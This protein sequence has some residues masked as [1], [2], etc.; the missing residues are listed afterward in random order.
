MPN[1]SKNNYISIAKALGI[2]LMVVGHSG[3]PTAIGKFIYLFH[4]PLFFVCSGYF[5]K[6]ISDRPSLF[7][8]YRKRIKGLY[9]PYLK[10]SLLFLLLHNLFRYLHITESVFYQKEDYIRQ[11]IKLIAMTDYELLIRPF[12]FIKELLFTSLI[13]ATIS[14]FTSRLSIK[15]RSV[16]LFVI[17]LIISVISK[18]LSPIPLIGDCSVLCLSIL[19]YYTGILFHKYRHYIPITYTTLIFSFAFVFTG[20]IIF[21]GTIDMRF[22]NIYNQIPYYLLSIA[23]IIMILCISQ[24]HE[25]IKHISA[26]YYIGNHTMPILALNLLALKLGSLLKIWIYGLPIEQLSSFTVIYEY[27]SWYW[28]IYSLIGVTIPLLVHF[29]YIKIV[30]MFISH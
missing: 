15:K 28:L 22:T 5:F 29:L 23:G 9:L 16:L 11:F 17:V 24:K 7:A 3:C 30:H 12:W 1:K 18:L 6:E 21:R 25:T 10:W 19:Y 4:M 8:F 13:V 27:N 14:F 20:S 26:L 2:I